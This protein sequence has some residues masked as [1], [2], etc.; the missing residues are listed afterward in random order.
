MGEAR[1]VPATSRRGRP[2]AVAS[3]AVAAAFGSV[4]V[5]AGEAAAAS[6]P[7]AWRTAASHSA[8]AQSVVAHSVVAHPAAAHS[9]AAWGWRL[10]ARW[11]ATGSTEVRLAAGGHASMLRGAGVRDVAVTVLPTTRCEG[12]W[13]RGPEQSFELTSGTYRFPVATGSRLTVVGWCP[14]PAGVREVTVLDVR[15]RPGGLSPLSP[16]SWWR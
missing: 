15:V 3:L 8:A 11:R 12:L 14:T 7:A 4:V 5:P 1:G 13:L 2:L 10:A 9:A 16:A 6:Q